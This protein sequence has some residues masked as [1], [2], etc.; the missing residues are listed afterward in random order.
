ML[1]LWLSLLSAENLAAETLR[2]ATWNVGLDRAG[3]GLLLQDIVTGDDPQIAADVEMRI[4]APPTLKYGAVVGAINAAARVR[5]Q[6][7][8]F[9]PPPGG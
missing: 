5:I 8:K 2:V 6:K 9:S 4:D 7:I 3:P 1:L